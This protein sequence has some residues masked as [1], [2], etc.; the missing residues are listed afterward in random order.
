MWCDTQLANVEKVNSMRPAQKVFSVDKCFFIP[1]QK[2]NGDF[3]LQII[4]VLFWFELFYHFSHFLL[5]N[6]FF[7][8][9]LGDSL[10]GSFNQTLSKLPSPDN[11]EMRFVFPN[12]AANNKKISF[13]DFNVTQVSVF[14]CE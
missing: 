13:I 4:L 2:L 3:F 8:L 9:Y 10:L 7:C 1:K 5:L 12:K 6:T 14:F 11:T